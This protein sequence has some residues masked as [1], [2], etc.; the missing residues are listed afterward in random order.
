MSFSIIRV[1][2]NLQRLQIIPDQNAEVLHIHHMVPGIILI[3]ISGYIAISFWEHSRIRL[4]MAIMFG[5]GAALTIDEFA[6]W[7]FLKDVYWTEQGRQSIDAVIF[8]ST[9]FTILFILSE[10]HDHYLIKKHF[11]RFLKRHP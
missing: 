8:T 5:M 11:G 10:V 7:L 2:T 3:L 4:S 9:L 1:V 6:L